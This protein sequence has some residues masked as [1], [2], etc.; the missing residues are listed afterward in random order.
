M[1]KFVAEKVEAVRKKIIDQTKKA[2]FEAFWEKNVAE[3]R[4]VPLKVE[5]TRMESPYDSAMTTYEVTYNTHDDTV[6]H[7][8][9][10]LPANAEKKLPCVVYFHGG[11]EKRVLMHSVVQTGVAVLSM[12]VRGQG[13]ISPDHA[14][15]QTGDVNG[16][17]MTKGVLDENEYYLKNIFLDAVRSMDVAAQFP[18]VDP[19][20]I[21]T[22]GVSQGGAL[23]IVASALSGRSIRCFTYVPSYCC[24]KQRILAGSRV[25]GSTHT[26]LKTYP[27]YTDRVFD[28]V[29]YFDVNNMVSLLKVPTAFNFNLDDP[30]CLPHFV[31]SAYS[32]ANCKKTLNVYPFLEHSLAPDF[33]KKIHWE[34]SRLANGEEM[35]DDTFPCAEHN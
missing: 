2:D 22:M 15:Y 21:V 27:Q 35:I 12:D 10:G 4:K 11:S 28:V 26:Y 16:G 13:G 34:L 9:F 17:L 23:S 8:Y 25:F 5:R 24:I 29:S 32:H 31:Y 19:N 33:Q 3:M 18:E 1:E 6:I 20:R 14:T 30:V 7:A